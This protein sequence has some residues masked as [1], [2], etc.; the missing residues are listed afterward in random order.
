MSG[1]YLPSQHVH[2]P[3]EELAHK[4]VAN[5]RDVEVAPL[6]MSKHLPPRVLVILA[7]LRPEHLCM[8]RGTAS[9]RR[10]DRDVTEHQVQGTSVDIF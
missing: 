2:D 8:G 10:Q 5:N 1:A 9:Q 3:H 6:Q 4:G 7:P